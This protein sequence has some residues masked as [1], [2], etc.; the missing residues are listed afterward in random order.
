MKVDFWSRQLQLAHG[1]NDFVD[2]LRFKIFQIFFVFYGVVLTGLVY[3]GKDVDAIR[4][5]LGGDVMI[6]PSLVL[7]IGWSLQVMFLLWQR[8]LYHTKAW[9]AA[10][11][12]RGD[13][14]CCS[15]GFNRN[16]GVEIS[17][18]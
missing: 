10:L 7:L 5:A 13:W 6:V 12:V 1:R 4:T 11:V 16:G 17:E 15:P 8:R 14:A 2:D 9:I 18:I 3:K